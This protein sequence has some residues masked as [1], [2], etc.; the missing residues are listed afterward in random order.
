MELRGANS[1]KEIIGA[2]E[3]IEKLNG[4]QFEAE[5]YAEDLLK[6]LQSESVEVQTA[7]AKAIGEVTKNNSE[8]QKLTD[9]KIITRLLELL[10]PT[11]TELTIQVSRALGNL[12]FENQK[13]RELA[14]GSD[15]VLYSLLDWKSENGLSS[16]LEKQFVK[17]RC[18]LISNFLV[19]S[20]E[21]A[22]SA[23]NQKII[24]K[25][26]NLL[27]QCADA[28][29]SEFLLLNIL[30][31]LSILSEM[32]DVS[33]DP[34]TTKLIIGVLATSSKNPD[35]GEICLE[36]LQ[37]QAESDD[38]KYLLAKEGLCDIL[39]ELLEKQKSD[40]ATDERKSALM[41]L[42]CDLIVQILN[43]DDAMHYL[44]TTKFL[45]C[46]EKWLDAYDPD[47]LV[48][49]VLALG[50]FAR[51]DSHCIDIVKRGV[52]KKL[53]GKPWCFRFD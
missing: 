48:C 1:T 13:A 23:I 10:T 47:L 45:Q 17:T 7:A 21:I 25:I 35:V 33:L 12:F 46:T 3:K 50:N 19:G 20:E 38:F 32:I 30:P 52:M 40:T 39:Y 29:K 37:C 34:P 44:Y 53:I 41:K 26:Q 5:N 11:A 9:A 4:E 18:G 36:I 51:T 15:A 14:K 24:S 16:D 42:S 28:E 22:K 27:K 31:P 2:L 43:G 8:R 6:V 49:A